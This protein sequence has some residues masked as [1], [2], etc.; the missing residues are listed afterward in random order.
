MPTKSN[1]GHVK[2]NNGNS[3][4][5]PISDQFGMI[6]SHAGLRATEF[7][8]KKR[9]EIY[10]EGEPAEYVYQILS[11]A[12]R[13]YKLLSDGRRQI[14]AFYL[15]GDVIG[16]ETGPSHR[17]T[18]EAIADTTVRPMLP[19]R[20]LLDVGVGLDQA[21]I[22]G[23]TFASNQTGRNACFDDTFEHATKNISLAEALVAGTRER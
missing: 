14:G 10:G 20:L 9:E 13:S 12:V 5:Y 19:P 1:A 2:S 8:Y 3:A 18:A 7:C 4:I 23:K 22:D 6:T 16:L 11:G 21:R 17:M 15:P